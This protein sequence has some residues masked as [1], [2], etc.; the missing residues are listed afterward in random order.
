ME[1]NYRETENSKKHRSK[2]TTERR[3]N[4]GN[5]N[6]ATYRS[7]HSKLVTGNDNKYGKNERADTNERP[8][9]NNTARIHSPHDYNMSFNEKH[10]SNYNRNASLEQPDSK[11]SKRLDNK[12]D[13]IKS[14]LTKLK[15]ELSN[16][17]TNQP[18]THRSNQD[19]KKRHHHTS[20]RR[21]A[22]KRDLSIKE[23]LNSKTDYQ[24]NTETDN[25]H[26]I[27]PTLK[28][29]LESIAADAS[30]Y[31]T[32]RNREVANDESLNNSNVV[33]KDEDYTDNSKTRKNNKKSSI[34]E[35]DEN[36]P[37]V[38]SKHRKAKAEDRSNNPETSLKING[39]SMKN[40]PKEI[41]SEGT[42]SSQIYTFREQNKNEEYFKSNSKILH[43]NESDN[44]VGTLL[45]IFLIKDYR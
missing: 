10:I 38:N 11:V 30:K 18:K 25:Y 7:E 24:V 39:I 2:N 35:G 26:V 16:F 32:H 20:K 6:P 21:L 8:S 12:L 23:N 43:S 13:C 31:K 42:H 3:M 27:S 19:Y 15:Q 41:S 28:R 14:G 22:K 29:E 33:Y 5:T 4:R 9:Q 40:L 1:L 37:I 44:V 45:I 34:R 17:N 36:S